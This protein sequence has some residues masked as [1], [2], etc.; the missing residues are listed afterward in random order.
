MP[1]S[2]THFDMRYGCNINKTFRGMISMPC[3][4]YLNIDRLLVTCKAVP[5]LDLNRCVETSLHS[6][7]SWKTQGIRGSRDLRC[8]SSS[9]L[10][11]SKMDAWWPIKDTS[12]NRIH[13]YF[14]PNHVKFNKHINE[15]FAYLWIILKVLIVLELQLTHLQLH[16]EFLDI[17]VFTLQCNYHKVII[18]HKSH[19]FHDSSSAVI[20]SHKGAAAGTANVVVPN[21]MHFCPLCPSTAERL[22]RLASNPR[23]SWA[24][25]KQRRFYTKTLVILH[26][27]PS[28]QKHF[29]TR[30]L[31]HTDPFT[32]RPF[33]TETLLHT[34]AFTQKRFYTQSL[35]HTDPVTHRRF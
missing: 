9:L 31:L 4:A 24:N 14:S 1:L 29:Y 22:W 33:Y 10:E 11:R 30:T 32:H 35:S 16:G 34:D 19:L 15:T 7:V 12:R 26:T 17:C 18:N 5:S 13:G 25:F 27:E 20:V 23:S 28:T 8:T 21:V 6:H 2:S 3:N